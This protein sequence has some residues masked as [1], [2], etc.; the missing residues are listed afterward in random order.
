MFSELSP[1]VV[2]HLAA[3][4]AAIVLGAL[5][6]LG[7]KGT[8]KHRGLGIAYIVSMLVT[9]VS[10]APV[11]ATSL[12]ILGTRFGFF[13]LMILVGAASLAIGIKDLLRWRRTREPAALKSHQINLA[14]SYAGLLMAGFS[15][16]ATNPR[17]MLVDLT[18][19]SQFW[20][21]FGVTNAAIYAVAAWLIQTRVARRDP[22][23][24]LVR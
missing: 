14:Y 10:V 24:F 15:Q 4:C 1:L 7:Q 19:L 17:W 16:L 20:F 9:I 18:S 3:A 12:P 13:H 2:V 8:A 21:V 11:R 6:F 23:S 22:L 5:L